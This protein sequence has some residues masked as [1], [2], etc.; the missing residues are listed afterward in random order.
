VLRAPGG[1]FMGDVSALLESIDDAHE[2]V[3]GPA[4]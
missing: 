3:H 1:T 4:R 2:A